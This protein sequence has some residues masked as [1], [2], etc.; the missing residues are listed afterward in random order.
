MQSD[1]KGE[2]LAT[3]TPRSLEITNSFP[4]NSSPYSLASVFDFIVAF[5]ILFGLALLACQALMET[6]KLYTVPVLR[7]Y[8][9]V[10]DGR[11]TLY[12]S[13]HRDVPTRQPASTSESEAHANPMANT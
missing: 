7:D 5:P 8:V 4:T 3:P 9:P 6:D 11:T 2:E 1:P 13:R 10:A 12:P